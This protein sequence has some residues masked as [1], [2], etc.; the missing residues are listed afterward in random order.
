M[1]FEDKKTRPDMAH[2]V[3]LEERERLSISGVE[4]VESFDETAVVVYTVK[5]TLI[6]RGEGLH[7]DRLSLDGGELSVEGTVDALQ[8]EAQRRES[9]SLF[10][11]L[12]R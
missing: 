4:D 6:V 5:G 10:S 9:G 11:R 1:A 7:I 12:F 3:I 2:H 8:Y